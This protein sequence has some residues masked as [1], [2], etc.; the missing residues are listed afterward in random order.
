LIR[1]RQLIDRF[2]NEKNKWIGDQVT[3]E[4]T[5]ATQKNINQEDK[6]NNTNYE[7]YSENDCNGNTADS[8][9]NEMLNNENLTQFIKSKGTEILKILQ[10]DHI[11]DDSRLT[12]KQ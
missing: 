2:N 10:E 1:Y 5:K 8:S 12:G 9:Q 7:N 6:E 11:W 4:N 3:S